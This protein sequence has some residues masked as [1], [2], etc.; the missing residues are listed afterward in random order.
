MSIFSVMILQAPVKTKKFGDDTFHIEAKGIVKFIRSQSSLNDV[1]ITKAPGPSLWYTIPY[2]LIADGSEESKY[3][4]YGVLW[5]LIII[6]ICTSLLILSV[7]KFLGQGVSW[8]LLISLYALPLHLYYSMGILAEPVAFC[9]VCLFAS[10]TVG[11][12]KQDKSK[13][14]VVLIVLGLTFLLTSR[15]NS[16]LVY[17]F[18]PLTIAYLT[19]FKKHKLI[20]FKKHIIAYTIA[21]AALILLT[22]NIK[23]LPTY[24]KEN[25]Q[26][27]YLFYVMHHG[28]FQFK[29]EKFD[30]RFW[31]PLTRPDSKDFQSWEKSSKALDAKVSKEKRPFNDVYIEW[32]IEDAIKDPWNIFVQSLVRLAFGNY[33]QVNSINMENRPLIKFG[34]LAAN[35]LN[36]II[37]FGAL[38]GLIK[39]YKENKS[40]LLILIPVVSLLIFHMFVYMEQK[41]LFPFRPILLLIF[42]YYAFMF[43]SRN[44][45][46]QSANEKN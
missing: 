30:W 21:L 24:N 25:A 13:W 4:N 43:L 2:L 27:S 7:F 28:R 45:K 22:F 34:L 14:Q 31:D 3:W 39:L 19:Q 44:I 5:N 23:H 35:I 29:T 33:L 12:L 18:F 8:I 11:L 38:L 42:S 17:I 1:Y 41:Y 10:G 46:K 36:I 6:S 37:L 32:L 15:P 40:W 26:E 16:I 20:E 9:G